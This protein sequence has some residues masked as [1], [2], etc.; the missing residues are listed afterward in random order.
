MPPISEVLAMN[1]NRVIPLPV[2]ARAAAS[3]LRDA[4]DLFRLERQGSLLSPASLNFDDLHVGKFLAWLELNYPGVGRF[5]DLRRTRCGATGPSWRPRPAA[6]TATCRRRPCSART[7]P[8]A[9]SCVGRPRETSPPATPAI[10]PGQ[11]G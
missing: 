9:S 8:C 3:Q 10:D 6:T 2:A 4:Y 5:G 1:K 7:A 11:Q